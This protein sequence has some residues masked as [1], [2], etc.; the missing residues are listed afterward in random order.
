[1]GLVRQHVVS[2]DELERLTDR[3]V[4]RE[5]DPFA[6]ADLVLRRLGVESAP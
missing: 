3:L 2:P 1:M 6:A 4:A 5:L